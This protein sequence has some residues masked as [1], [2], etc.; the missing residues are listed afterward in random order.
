MRELLRTNDPVTISRIEAL[1][2]ACGIGY[3][4]AD[5]HMS[6][7]DGS[8]GAIPRRILVLEEDLSAARRHVAAIGLGA[9]LPE[10]GE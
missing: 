1:L 4:V 5:S 2:S 7:L 8:I 10:I 3:F 6:F 9:E